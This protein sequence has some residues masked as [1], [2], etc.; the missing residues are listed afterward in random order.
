MNLSANATANAVA[1]RKPAP[2]AE[3]DSAISP[4]HYELVAAALRYLEA[5]REEQP[6]LEETAAHIGLSPAHFQR[7]F[8]RLV[9]VSPKRYLQHLTMIEARRHL[10]RRASVL[11]AA[12]ASGL[13]APSRLHD[14]FLRWEAMTPGSFARGGAGVEIAWGFCPS[15]FG[16]VLAMATPRGLAGLAFAAEMGRE[17]TFADMAARWPEARLVEDPAAVAP[18]VEAAFAPPAA[19]RRP[20]TL[21]PLGGPFQIKVWEAL[22]SIPEGA[23]TTYAAIARAI[24]HPGAARAVGRAVGQNPIALLIPCHRVLRRDGGLGG[25]HWGLGVKRA[26]LAAEL[27]RA[28][29]GSGDAAPAAPEPA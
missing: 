26:L 5:H 8:S 18:L 10:A 1:N 20:L 19:R 11:D 6:S 13:S 17:A 7:L 23:L 9:G 3:S 27:A 22:L 14:L 28:E 2:P 21:A 29:A 25:Y 16:E 12:Y 15:P 4:F 24:G